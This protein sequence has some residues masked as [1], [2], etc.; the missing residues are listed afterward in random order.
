MKVLLTG[1][2]GFIGKPLTAALLK[3]GWAVNALVRSPGNADALSVEALGARLVPGDVT[4]PET[5]RAAVKG[6]DIVIN[7][8][9]W[10]ALGIGGKE[11]Q[12][13]MQA[14]NVDG[15]RTVLESAIEAGAQRIV[16]VSSIV[17]W[18]PTGNEQ[19]DESF[20]R[21]MAPTTIYERTKAEAHDLAAALQKQGA[22]IVIAAP[23]S[24][25]GA[26]DHAAMGDLIRLYVRGLF[27]PMGMYGEGG[28]TLVHV[29]DCAEAIALAA[30]EGR[31]GESYLL[32]GEFATYRQFFGW[33]SEKPGGMRPR[34]YLPNFMAGIFCKVAE[35]VERMLGLPVTFSADTAN[36][37]HLQ[38][39]Y[40][41]A[42]AERELGAK[43]RGARQVVHDAVD[44]E[45]KRLGMA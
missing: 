1:A 45:R 26:G 23:T 18:G 20:T 9:G 42:K 5:V 39:N 14:I 17:A 38:Y 19:R 25:H 29:D 2:T 32:G 13:Q 10:Y 37:A 30:E 31:V 15:A 43:F 22:P 27:P 7:N 34:L 11:A 3:R 4:Q 36:S 40:S 21:Q 41:G 44:G 24:V 16:H 8:A 6:A 35:P 28:R 33:I 12:A